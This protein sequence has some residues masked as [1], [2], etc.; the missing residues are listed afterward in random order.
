LPFLTVV[1]SF[2][3]TSEFCDSLLIFGLL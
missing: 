1:L 3:A 2:P